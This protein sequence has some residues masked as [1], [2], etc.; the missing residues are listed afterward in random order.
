MNHRRANSRTRATAPGGRSDLTSNA[1]FPHGARW[2]LA[3]WVAA[4][5]LALFAVAP[6]AASSLVNIVIV[7]PEPSAL[8]ARATLTAAGGAVERAVDDDHDGQLFLIPPAGAGEYRLTL[9]LGEETTTRELEVPASSEV[10]LTYDAGATGEKLSVEV[11]RSNVFEGEVVVTARKREENLQET[12]LAI[13]V[14]TDDAIE[15]RSMRDLRDVSDYTPNLNF[16]LGGGNGGGAP[17][18][19]TVYIRGLGQI[20]T[21]IYSDPGVGIYVDGV[22]LARAQGSVVDLFDLERVEVL[23]GPQGTLFGKNTTGGAIQLVTK[24]PDGEFNGYLQGTFGELDRLDFTARVDGSLGENLYASLALATRNRDGYTRSLANGETMNDDNRDSARIAVRWLASEKT[25]AD[26]SID[27][28]RERRSAL[29]QKLISVIPADL[30]DFYNQ[31]L[32]GAGLTPLTDAFITDDLFTSYSDFPSRSDGD[33]FGTNFQFNHLFGDWNFHSITAYRRYEYEGSA[34]FDGA[35][36]RL[37]DRSYQQEQDQFSQELQISGV[38]VDDRLDWFLGALYFEENPVD[39]GVANSLVEL[40]GAL[41]AAPGAIYAPP[42][43]PDSFCDPGPPP[44]GVPCFG[45]AD[46]PLNFAFFNGDGQRETLA[47]DTTSTAL[48]GEATLAVNDRLSATAGVRYTY[49]EKAFDFQQLRPASPPLDL[50]AEETW[51]NWSPRVSLAYQARDNALLYG[52][53]ARGFKSGGFN[54]RLF[55]RDQ[56]DPYDEEKVWAYEAGFKTDFLD[57]RLRFNGAAFYSDYTDIQF[58]AALVI[59]G[60]PTFIVLNAAEARVTGIELELEARPIQGLEILAGIGYI[61]SEY[62]KV[63]SEGGVPE[64][65]VLPKTPEWDL[66][67]GVQYAFEVD[68]TGALILRGDYNYRSEYFNEITNSPLV[69]ENGYGLVN[70]RVTFAPAGKPWEVALFGT[71]LTDERFIEAGAVSPAIGLASVIAG[72][73]REWGLSLEYRF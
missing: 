58:S 19:A 25:T 54:G 4:T 16:T 21:G 8:T 6:L 72:R 50:F 49:E 48:F 53:I 71:N 22:Y 13:T 62:T 33:I 26:F 43:V 11:E 39:R 10:R 28:L 66:N 70:A 47:I 36:N 65:G 61:D 56:L 17:S 37:F 1:S 32:V 38:A 67:F 23:R 42:G 35:P 12:P 9:E 7:D 3:V 29:D 68:R 46:N 40:F 18:E 64:N 55:N 44:P 5:C 24:K 45:G 20:D 57:R 2:G 31:A 60:V 73:P 27:A 63:E 34:D 59:D 41:E 51:D 14:I 30:L 15:D 52:S 69:A